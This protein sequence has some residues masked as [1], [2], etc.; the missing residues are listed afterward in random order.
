MTA[1]LSERQ[2]EAWSDTDL[3]TA[4][5]VRLGENY[6]RYAALQDKL[7]RRILL[8]CEKLKLEKNG[9]PP[10]IAPDGTVDEKARKKFFKSF[11]LKTRGGFNTEKYGALLA[12]VDRDIEKLSKLTNGAIQLEP[13]KTEKKNKLQCVYWQNIRD[14]AQRLFDSLSSRLSPCVCTHPHQANLRLDIREDRDAKEDTTRFAFLLTFEKRSEPTSSPP[15]VWRD[16][17]IQPSQLLSTAIAVT[18][19]QVQTS[20]KKKAHFTP[21]LTVSSYS[22][23]PTSRSPSPGLAVKIDSLCRSLVAAY[24]QDCYLGVL[25]DEAWQHHVYSFHGPGFKSQISETVSLSDIIYGAKRIAPRQKCLLALTLASSVLQLHDTP[26]LPCTW[27]TKDIMFLKDHG[28]KPIP[29]QFY[30]SQTF[31]SASQVAAVAKRRRLVKNETVFALGVALLELAHGA[32]ILSFK[33]PDDLNEDGKEDETTEVSIATRLARE[34]NNY[35]SE[36]YAR[37]VLRCITCTFDTFVFG[38]D[39]WEFREAFYQA[40]IVP[41]QEDYGHLTGGKP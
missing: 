40:V 2:A 13:V 30:V 35:E 36:N 14:Q 26:W 7:N 39:K 12:D 9:Q 4:L 15:W 29:S 3:Q 18:T 1:L 5:K 17:E 6:N 24:Q 28:G 38:F 21:S 25:K 23:F 10:W 19:P 41:L 22:Q 32:S 33:E 27:E 16:V 37:A 8:F 11:W 31:T 20:G 34:L